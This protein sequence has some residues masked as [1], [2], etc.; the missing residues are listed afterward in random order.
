[1]DIGQDRHSTLLWLTKMTDI[2]IGFLPVPVTLGY[3][4]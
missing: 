2:D 4:S 1:V 3:G